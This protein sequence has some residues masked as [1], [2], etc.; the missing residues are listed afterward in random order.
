MEGFEFNF[1]SGILVGYFIYPFVMAVIESYRR[2]KIAIRR[3]NGEDV[4]SYIQFR[5]KK[6]EE[7][8]RLD[9][10]GMTYKGVLIKDAGEAHRAFL[11]FMKNAK[12]TVEQQ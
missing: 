8:L 10:E 1:L 5:N 11:E 4:E 7:V 2:V 3:A 9:D 6:M 12:E